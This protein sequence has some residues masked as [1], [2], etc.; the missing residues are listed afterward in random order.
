MLTNAVTGG[1]GA[2]YY[3]NDGSSDL[4]RC[5]NGNGTWTGTGAI[6]YADADQALGSFPNT[7]RLSLDGVTPLTANVDDYTWP[8]TTIQNLYANTTVSA[9]P[10]M[11]DLCTYASQPSRIT[12]VNPNWSASC[13]MKHTKTSNFGGFVVNTNYH[14][15]NCN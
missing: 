10:I 7:V 15:A 13:N 2:H 11:Q 14:N 3:F 12:A 1:T 5:V 6:G 8:F 9:T 4:M